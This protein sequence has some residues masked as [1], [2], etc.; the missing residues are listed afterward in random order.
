MQDRRVFLRVIGGGTAAF[1]AGCGSTSPHIFGTGG[2]GAGGDAA[3]SS[4]GDAVSSSSSD[5]ASSSG[6][7]GTS[8]TGPGT[9]SSVASSS[10]STGYSSSAGSSSSSSGSTCVTN[11]PGTKLGMPTDYAGD[12]LHIVDGAA[13]LIGRDAGGLY[14]LTAVCTHQGCDMSQK[15]KGMLNGSL[16]NSDM[17][18]TCACHG[19][20]FNELG[21]V[22]NGPASSPLKAYALALGCD[23]FLYADKSKV[24]A[25]TVRLMA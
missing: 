1:A 20:E 3:S 11:P 15:Y 8:S 21:A 7:G 5:A 14:A 9:S 6:T 22:V 16:S 17:D 19:S 4:A 24:V 18:I 13:V 23:G 25:N 12:G 10:G 2:G